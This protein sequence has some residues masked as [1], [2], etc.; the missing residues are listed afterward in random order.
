MEILLSRG[1]RG[2]SS[3]GYSKIY[4]DIGRGLSS[5]SLLGG[6]VDV[7]IELLSHSGKD[8]PINI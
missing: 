2:K 8:L 5:N 1:E 4:E 6:D 3:S 7:F